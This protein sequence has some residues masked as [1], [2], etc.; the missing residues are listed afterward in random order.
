M[1]NLPTQVNAGLT[2]WIASKKVSSSAKKL[3]RKIFKSFGE[4][5]E[6][7]SEKDIITLGAL[8]G[9]GPA[10]FFYLCELMMI[11]AE[12]FGFNE[13][14]ART[15]AEKT[16]IGAAKLLAAHDLKA[17]DWRKAVSS[18]KGITVEAIKA[19]QRNG[20]HK[21][22]FKGIDRAKKR[23]EEMSKMG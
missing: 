9:C 11:K 10:Y 12:K 3:I 6:L 4:E 21:V 13:N 15:I 18:K 19:L 7:H 1:P 22:F 2:G 17:A 8:S 5:I 23:T 16:F 20:F 14:D